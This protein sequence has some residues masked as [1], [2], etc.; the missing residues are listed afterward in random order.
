[1]FIE[2]RRLAGAMA[3]ATTVIL[4]G[5]ASATP[6]TAAGTTAGTTAGSAVDAAAPAAPCRTPV[7]LT[8]GGVGARLDRFDVGNHESGEDIRYD[9]V[10]IGLTRPATSYRVRYVPQITQ[11]GSGAPIT[12]RGNA[13]LEVIIEGAD[14]HD[15]AGSTVPVR[16]YTRDWLALREARIVSDFE[17]Y[18]QVGLGVA[19]PVDFIVSTLTGPDRLVIDLAVPG[20]HPWPCTSGTVQV[21]FFNAQNFVDNIDPFFVPVWRRVAT[22]AVAGGAL[23]SLFHGPVYTETQAGLSLLASGATGFADLRIVNGYAHVRLTGGCNSGGS[24]V[25]VGASIIQ[26]LLQFSTVRY[27]KIYDPD[28]QTGDPTGPDNSVPDCLNP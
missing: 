10:V 20:T 1:M 24:T 13:D 2:K 9:R 12:L 8:V 17:G 3:A 11:D 14:A 23:H 15:E 7:D 25:S 19:N 4:I 26:T 6:A 28:G 22:P 16:R 21:Y 18:V 27:V 5:G